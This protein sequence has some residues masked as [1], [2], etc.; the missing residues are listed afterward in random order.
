MIRAVVCCVDDLAKP[1]TSFG[2]SGAC[3]TKIL[4]F[5]CSQTL[6]CLFALHPETFPSVTQLAT[7]PANCRLLL[8]FSPKR[9]I[10]TFDKSETKTFSSFVDCQNKIWNI[11][12]FYI[13]ISICI[14]N[15][16][17]NFRIQTP[18]FGSDIDMCHT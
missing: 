5:V 16:F 4:R 1:G 11:F 17:T 9:I 13:F 18:D 7:L 3:E 6:L 14:Y 10:P 12:T 15:F 8:H 2:K